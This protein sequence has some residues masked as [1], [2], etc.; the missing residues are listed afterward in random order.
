M[1][2]CKQFREWIWLAVN[3]ELPTKQSEILKEHIKL[4]ADCQL[5]REE[6]EKT[7]KLLNQKIQ[8]EPTELQLVSSRTELHQR[9]LVIKQS[10]MKRNWWA[11]LWHIVSLDF[12]PGLRLAT[13]ATLLII[14]IVLGK[15]FF[16]Q[17]IS[18]SQFDQNLLSGLTESNISNIESIYFDPKTG[19][20]SLKLNT[21]NEITIEGDLEKPEI[22][23]LL[24]QTLMFDERPDIRLKIVRALEQTKTL[25]KN[26]IT[27]LAELLDKEEN[28]GIRLKA[29]K[30]L[31]ALPI[32]PSLKDILAQVL[33]RVLL[34]DS[35]SA[36]RI[37]AFKGLSKVKNG[38]MAPFIANAAK[39]DSS[40]YIRTKAKQI[41]DRTENPIIPQ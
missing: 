19:E 8:L 17:T 39:N 27:A 33:V 41:L 21:M 22:Q 14:G 6:A 20:V 2:R 16:T 1:E 25:D 32:T 10:Q 30:L 11:K 23:H 7:L 28:P 38:S 13:A 37:E 35:N 4:C 29:V 9:L 31:T 5:D 3:D 40:E 34:N 15:I 26:V 36:I 24:T 18:E 12:A